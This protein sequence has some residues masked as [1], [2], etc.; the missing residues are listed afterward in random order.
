M[1]P[2]QILVFENKQ[3][4]LFST[5]KLP[6]DIVSFLEYVLIYMK[7]L[8]FPNSSLIINLLVSRSTQ[9]PFR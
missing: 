2:V 6:T 1:R 8:E 7:Y 4:F 9:N 5:M 3:C